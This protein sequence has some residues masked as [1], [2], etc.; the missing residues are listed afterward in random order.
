MIWENRKT[1]RGAIE[2]KVSDLDLQQFASDFTVSF[3]DGEWSLY[4]VGALIDHAE[5]SL[6]SIAIDQRT[7]KVTVA[8]STEDGSVTFTD[9]GVFL[10]C[11]GAK[12][13]RLAKSKA[14]AKRE[15]NLRK[16]NLFDYV[17]AEEV[18]EARVK[19]QAAVSAARALV[20]ESLGA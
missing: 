1:T 8:I 4:D 3:L 17:T 2:I 9:A 10:Y 11:Y 16:V 20:L 7:G 18:A 15:A 13:V 5:T 6:R 12:S 14:R 19:M